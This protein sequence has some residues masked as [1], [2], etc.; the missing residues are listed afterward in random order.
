[1]I[2]GLTKYSASYFNI[3]YQNG[4]LNSL[5]TD[6]LKTFDHDIQSISAFYV[7]ILLVF[8]ILSLHQEVPE[9]AI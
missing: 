2:Q 6:M 9:K 3:F 7:N 5:T 1:M 8:L 4:R